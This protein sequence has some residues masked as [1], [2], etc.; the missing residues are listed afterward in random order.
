NYPKIEANMT[1][2]NSDYKEIG[3]ILNINDINDKQIIKMMHKSEYELVSKKILEI[4]S[5]KED[6][7]SFDF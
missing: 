4:N 3:K 7:V 1:I 6:N 5:L 2:I